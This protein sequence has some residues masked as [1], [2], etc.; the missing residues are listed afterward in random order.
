V[1]RILIAD[2]HQFVREGLK[3]ILSEAE[4][5]VVAAEAS[6]GEE[7]LDKLKTDNFDV[8]ILDITMPR[9]TGIEVLK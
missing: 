5:I 8:M 1:I 6:N 4:D 7:V 9:K 2:D 3:M